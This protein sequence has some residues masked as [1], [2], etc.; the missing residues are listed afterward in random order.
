MNFNLIVYIVVSIM[1]ISG[2][3]YLNFS[4]GKS[5]QAIILGV[6]FLLISVIFGLRWFSSAFTHPTDTSMVWPPALNSCPD[7][8]TLTKINDTAV[9][10]D[11][12]G[13]SQKQDVLSKWTDPTQTDSK[14]I[15]NLFLNQSGTQRVKSICDA[16]KAAKITWEGV[17]DGDVCLNV[18]PPRPV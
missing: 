8:L 5:I 4:N 14:Y 3:F 16:C 9:C 10:V 1:M 18:D 12:V 11:T 6:G 17:W 2:S 13:V 7:Y 15:F